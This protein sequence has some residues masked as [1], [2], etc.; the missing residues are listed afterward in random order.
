M[1]LYQ[2]LQSLHVAGRGLT[3]PPACSPSCSPTGFLR[4]RAAGKPRPGR[5]NRN[6]DRIAHPASPGDTADTLPADTRVRRT[7]SFPTR[8]PVPIEESLMQTRSSC[9][10]PAT[11]NLAGP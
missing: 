5:L 4:R 6:P 2:Q 11:N 9:T 7:P 3:S 1:W 10:P 8:A